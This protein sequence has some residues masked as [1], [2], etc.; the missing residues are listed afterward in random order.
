MINTYNFLTLYGKKITE[1]FTIHPK[2]EEQAVAIKAILKALKVPF[3]KLENPFDEEFVEMVKKAD[4]DFKKDK[5][6]TISLDEVWK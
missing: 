6:K 2:D 3:K 1:A 4:K 5:G